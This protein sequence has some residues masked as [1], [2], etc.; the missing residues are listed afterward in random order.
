M[1]GCPTRRLLDFV[2]WGY[3]N[4][5]YLCTFLWF[6]YCKRSTCTRYICPSFPLSLHS[7]SVQRSMYNRCQFPCGRDGGRL[8]FKWQWGIEDGRRAGRWLW[9][10]VLV[11]KYDL[12][13][14]S[15]FGGT[16]NL[17]S[18]DRINDDWP[19]GDRQPTAKS[20]R[21]DAVAAAGCW[22]RRDCGF[23]QKNSPTSTA[24]AVALDIKQAR[25][26]RQSQ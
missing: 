9:V 24:S 26:R 6:S 2:S 10:M 16:T 4:L 5:C 11:Y 14:K 7:Q 22:W 3:V 23:L 15:W 19:T 21:D 18:S 12:T 13:G 17:R 20:T 1:D 25:E 8:M